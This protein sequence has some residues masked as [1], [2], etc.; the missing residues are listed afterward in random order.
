M[1]ALIIPTIKCFLEKNY[2]PGQPILLGCSGGTDSLALFHALLDC[3][4]FFSLNLHVAHID[5]SWRRESAREAADL[6]EHIDSKGIP[7][8]LSVAKEGEGSSEEAARHLRFHF[9][10]QLYRQLGCQ[11]LLLGH[12]ADDQAETVLKRILEGASLSALAGIR[13]IMTYQHMQV[14]RPLLTIPKKKMVEWVQ[15]KGLSAVEDPTNKEVKY[16]RS[17]MRVQIIPQLEASFG[18]AVSSNLVRLGTLASEMREYLYRK[19]QLFQ[20][21]KKRNLNELHIDFTPY[22]PLD[23]FELKFFLKQLFKEEGIDIS[24]RSLEIIRKLIEN[25]SKNKI[26]D[27]V[28]IN[29]GHLFLKINNIKI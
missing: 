11:A 4:S 18:K 12:H 19:N 17:R 22:Y 7:F 9:F 21:E 29:Y 25:K 10:M 23:S 27:T 3:A 16:L 13:E 14:W 15:K 24:F 28:F 20:I 8:Y 1:K 26:V 2:K 6:K 5:H